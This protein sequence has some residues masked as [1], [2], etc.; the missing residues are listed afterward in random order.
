MKK[1]RGKTKSVRPEVAKLKREKTKRTR[2][3]SS[4]TSRKKYWR[5]GIIILAVLLM[6]GLFSNGFDFKTSEKKEEPHSLPGAT[7]QVTSADPLLGDENAEITMV[8][9]GDFQCPFCKKVHDEALAEFRNSNYFKNGEVNLVYKHLPLRGHAFAQKAAEA[10]E[11][12]NRQD[13]F[14]EYHDVIFENQQALDIPD[15]KQYAVQIDLDT[16]EFNKC[17]DEG[18]ASAKVLSDLNEA[19]DSGARGTPYFVIINNENGQ[20]GTVTGA[21]PWVN[22]KTAIDSLR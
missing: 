2:T 11:C 22:F 9:F 7:L 3:K 16:N 18:E 4:L 6:I 15:L 20:R 5:I 19:I 21:Q 8:E 17:L 13:K 12:A 10:S 1:K 14:W